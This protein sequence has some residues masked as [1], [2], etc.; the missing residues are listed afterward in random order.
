MALSMPLPGGIKTQSFG[1]SSMAIQP[2]MYYVGTD[3]AWWQPFSGASFGVN[4]HAGVDFAG[5]PA[6]SALVAAEAGTVTRAEY[7]K[8][9]G[10]GW[11]VEVEIKPGVRYSYNHC[12]S[13]LAW[14]GKVSKGQRIASVGATGTIWNG[15][16]FVRS[17]YGVH[18]HVV[19]SIMTTIAT[20]VVRPV[21]YDFADF[22]SGGSKA[23]SSLVQ[24]ATTTYPTVKVRDGVNIRSTPDLDVGST[25]IAYVCRDGYIYASNGERKGYASKTFQ[26]RGTVTNDDG[27]WGKLYGFDRYL[28]VMNG[29]YY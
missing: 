26:L 7:D 3:R 4:V 21:L 24:P 12:Q 27:T 19:M 15:T 13:L 2:S 14:G 22:M 25:N 6:G 8:Y 18:V 9:N 1:P 23:G 11:V 16:S 20:G 5:M 29:L 17:T 28:Y 10:G